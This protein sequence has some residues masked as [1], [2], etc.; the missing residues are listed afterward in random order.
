M[1]SVFVLLNRKPLYSIA[2]HQIS[3][4][5]LTPLLIS[6]AKTIGFHVNMN[7]ILLLIFM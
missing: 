2:S 6:S 3:N 7:L 1:Y 5:A 4:L